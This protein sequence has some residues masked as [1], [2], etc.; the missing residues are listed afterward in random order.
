VPVLC[1]YMSN[2][3]AQSS[4]CAGNYNIHNCKL[5]TKPVWAKHY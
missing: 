2:S 3:F 1:K 5:N 4:R